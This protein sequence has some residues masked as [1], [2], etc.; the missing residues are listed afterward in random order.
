MGVVTC[1]SRSPR[2]LTV[3]VALL[4][5]IA[6][7]SARRHPASAAYQQRARNAWVPNGTV[8][9]MAKAGSTVYLGGDFTWLT[10]PATGATVARARLAAV[11][12]TTGAP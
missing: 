8:Y 10:N 11:D 6:S 3:L 12:A 9:A 1:T 5:T 4:V 7:G 2:A